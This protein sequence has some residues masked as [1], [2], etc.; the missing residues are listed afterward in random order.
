MPQPHLN[1]TIR[2]IANRL[3]GRTVS[4]MQITE[5]AQSAGWH[6]PI[7][8]SLNTLDMIER[9]TLGKYMIREAEKS[10]LSVEEIARL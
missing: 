3:T 9:F 5:V 6:G 7:V 1:Q 8:E 10:G 2:G 4:D